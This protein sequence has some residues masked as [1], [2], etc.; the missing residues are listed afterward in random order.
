ML[1]TEYIS[2]GFEILVSVSLVF[3]TNIL[4]LW[5]DFQA[6]TSQQYHLDTDSV[7]NTV[8]YFLS[9]LLVTCEPHLD[10]IHLE[11]C[12]GFEHT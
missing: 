12:H 1:E 11:I 2:E 3:I 5:H 8:P 7:T 6:L 4:F 10:A 9:N